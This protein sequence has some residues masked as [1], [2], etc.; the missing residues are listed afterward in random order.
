[1]AQ[2]LYDQE[3]DFSWVEHVRHTPARGA[4]SEQRATEW[5]APSFV[6]KRDLPSRRRSFIVGIGSA[7]DFLGTV[8]LWNGTTLY[9][10]RE[11]PPNR[12][13]ALAIYSDWCA[14][15]E[16]LHGAVRNFE[17]TELEHVE[18]HTQ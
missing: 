15:G 9:R 7:L 16:D 12:A 4:A 2:E 14:I 18:L 3:L 1:M 10:I 6:C 13:N 17:R 5:H 11:L 8:R